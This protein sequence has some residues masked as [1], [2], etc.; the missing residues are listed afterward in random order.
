MFEAADHSALGRKLAAI[1]ASPS[2]IKTMAP[3]LRDSSTTITTTP[4]TSVSVTTR[5]I[6][7][8]FAA[9]G[10]ARKSVQSS[11]TSRTVRLG[12]LIRSCQ[13]QTD[14]RLLSTLSNGAG[15]RS[16]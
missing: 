3:H 9:S 7:S 10:A 6:G 14:L 5:A 4:R 8:P 16:A 15:G 2:S 11:R 1:P 12:S 13:A